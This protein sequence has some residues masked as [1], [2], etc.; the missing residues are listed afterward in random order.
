MKTLTALGLIA[1]LFSV[2]E[3]PVVYSDL[4]LNNIL[5]VYG[6]QS[7][8]IPMCQ[9]GI[10]QN[11]LRIV[12]ELKLPYISESND[13]SAFFYSGP[14]ESPFYLGMLHNHPRGFCSP[15]D[16]DIDRFINDEQATIETIVC[17]VD[18]ETGAVTLNH[19][20]KEDLPDSL[21]QRYKR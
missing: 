9:F 6:G 16:M 21:I 19:T 2:Q 7:R 8:E 17:G 12:T 4:T 15:G 20:L 13:S 5:M 1:T 18:M 14:C 3:Y 10:E 11:G